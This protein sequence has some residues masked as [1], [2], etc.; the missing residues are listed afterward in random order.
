MNEEAL[1]DAYQDFVDTGYNGSI[2]DFSELLKSNP[3]AFKDS[4]NSFVNTGYNGSEDDFSKLLGLETLGFIE[5]AKEGLKD[6]DINSVSEFGYALYDIIAN[7]LPSSVKAG[8]AEQGG[9]SI[10]Y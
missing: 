9:L 4:Y 1:N 10:F 8:W 5:K 7:R 3:E 2:D 6:G